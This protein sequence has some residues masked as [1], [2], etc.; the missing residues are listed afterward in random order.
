ML[1]KIKQ[2]FSSLIEFNQVHLKQGFNLDTKNFSDVRLRV[3]T[4]IFPTISKLSFDLEIT[5]IGVFK[6]HENGTDYQQLLW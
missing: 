2:K 1:P 6:F 5:Y 3:Y 4:S